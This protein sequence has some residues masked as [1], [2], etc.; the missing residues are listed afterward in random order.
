[1][2]SIPFLVR[3][4]KLRWSVPKAR[5]HRRALRRLSCATPVG[6]FTLREADGLFYLSFRNKTT[7]HVSLVA[8]QQAAQIEF[9]LCV[10]ECLLP[11]R[12]PMRALAHM[13]TRPVSRCRAGE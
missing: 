4:R 12:I 7:R 13:E 2:T 8:A 11:V 6:F 9:E 3:F 5:K 1:M 10:R